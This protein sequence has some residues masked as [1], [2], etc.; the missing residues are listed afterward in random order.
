LRVIVDGIP[1][2]P[3]ATILEKRRHAL[4]AL[5]LSVETNGS[6]TRKILSPAVFFSAKIIIELKP[7]TPPLL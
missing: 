2:I 4:E 6:S 5:T 3:G 7:S 1:E